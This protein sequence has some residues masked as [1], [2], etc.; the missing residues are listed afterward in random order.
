VIF[1]KRIID[2]LWTIDQ[3]RFAYIDENTI[4]GRCPVCTT[5]HIRVDFHGT[6]PRADLSCSLGCAELDIAR[7][8]VGRRAIR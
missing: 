1:R 6:T 3:Q 5:G 2:A 4:G 7:G 8:L